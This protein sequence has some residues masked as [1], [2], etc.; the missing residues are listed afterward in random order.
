MRFYYVILTTIEKANP[1]S[2]TF[3]ELKNHFEN[4]DHLVL[5]F[6]ECKLVHHF[7]KHFDIIL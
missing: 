7:G 5:S 3:P 1:E 4:E 6:W 2:F